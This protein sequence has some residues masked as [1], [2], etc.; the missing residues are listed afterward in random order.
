METNFQTADNTHETKLTEKDVSVAS[1]D[2]NCIVY[3]RDRK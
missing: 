1:S 3:Y 2:I